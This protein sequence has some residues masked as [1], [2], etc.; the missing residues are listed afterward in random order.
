MIIYSIKKILKKYGEDTVVLIA[1]WS[2]YEALAVNNKENLMVITLSV[3]RC[4]KYTTDKKINLVEN[5]E[6]PN[7]WS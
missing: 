6:N 7:D 1:C 3:F 5:S 4:L 2:F